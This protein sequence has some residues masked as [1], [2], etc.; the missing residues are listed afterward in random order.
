VRVALPCGPPQ[1]AEDLDFPVLVVR[2]K[3]GHPP[4]LSAARRRRLPSAP[5]IDL[6]QPNVTTD[7][8]ASMGRENRTDCPETAPDL[9]TQPCDR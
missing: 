3:C 2:E 8:P 4:I 7:A 9:L 1:L 5:F 6:I